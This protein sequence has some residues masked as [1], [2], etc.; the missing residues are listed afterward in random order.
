VK[1]VREG[2][3]ASQVAAAHGLNVRTVYR[4]LADFA[5]GGQN[6]LLAKSIPG[7]PSKISEQELMWLAKNIREH[8]PQQFKFEFGL[9]TLSLIGSLIE[10]QFGKSLALSGVSR[11]MKL[12]GFTAQKPLY[13]AWQHMRS[14]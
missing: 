9:W 1:A 7:R 5:N 8:S 14:W 4:W 3:L 10:R 13:Q 2:Q 6:A 12:P 11:I